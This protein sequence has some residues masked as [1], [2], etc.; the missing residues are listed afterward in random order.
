ML[1]GRLG[2]LAD[3]LFELGCVELGEFTLKEHE[4]KDLPLS[5]VK[6]NFRTLSHPSGPG[7]LT[8]IGMAMIGNA[9]A[10]IV[11]ERGLKLDRLV[12]LP[13]A[14]EPIAESMADALSLS[15]D[16]LIRLNKVNLGEGKRKIVGPIEGKLIYG[17]CC[18]MVDD[19]ISLSRS[20]MEGRTVL[21]RKGA[22]LKNLLVIV[23]RE[24]GGSK[25]MREIGVEVHCLFPA[26]VLLAH[27]V[28]S[29]HIG[30]AIADSYNA[31]LAKSRI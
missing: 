17:E 29:G 24:Q 25:Q 23:D 2:E 12:G 31:Y 9:M 22:T 30:A 26:R 5:P 13:S 11:S 15:D 7:P 28:A 4:S 18:V 19:V 3:Y 20:K 1:S 6:F 14:G 8:P 16:Q 27:G 10:S 21:A